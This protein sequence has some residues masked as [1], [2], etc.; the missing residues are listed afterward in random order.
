MRVPGTENIAPLVHVVRGE[1]VLFDAY[2]AALYG[3][4][5]KALNQAVRRNRERFSG[6]FMFRLTD[7]EWAALRSQA[8]TTSSTAAM[9]SQIVTSSRRRLGTLP[10]AFTEQ[11]V[12]F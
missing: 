6:D 2:L 8:V 3:V 10:D 12:E 1:K 4:A 7:R 5:T 11:S 9:R